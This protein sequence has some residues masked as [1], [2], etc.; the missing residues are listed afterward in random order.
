M[1]DDNKI[2]HIGISTHYICTPYNSNT[3]KHAMFKKLT[4]K[5]DTTDKIV[6]LSTLLP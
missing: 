3:Q 6:P 4:P 1:E 2:V 5:N